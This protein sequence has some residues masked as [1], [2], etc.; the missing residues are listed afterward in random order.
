MFPHSKQVI[1]RMR[2]HEE[3]PSTC[4]RART[5]RT[6]QA[7]ITERYGWHNTENSIK[8]DKELRERRKI[9]GTQHGGKQEQAQEPKSNMVDQEYTLSGTNTKHKKRNFYRG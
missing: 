9:R 7:E 4:R 6:P 2:Y 8:P 5:S 3:P 1:Q